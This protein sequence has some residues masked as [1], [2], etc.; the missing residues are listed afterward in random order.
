MKIYLKIFKDNNFGNCKT[1]L[2]LLTTNKIKVS[3]LKQ[4]IF[5]KYGIEKSIQRL[6]IKLFNK[7]FITMSEEFPLLFFKIKE[8]SIIFVEILEKVKIKED[9]LKKIKQREGKSKYLRRLNIFKKRPNMDIIQESEIED[10]DDMG[11]KSYSLIDK[12]KLNLDDT[13]NNNINNKNNIN[14]YSDFNKNIEKRFVNAVIN[15]KLNEFREIITHYNEFID[16]N[17]PIRNNKKYSVIHYASKNEY[18]EMMEDL[19]N[20]YNANVNLISLDGWS[21]LHIS[22]Y[23]GNLKII[24]ILINFKKT[25]FDLV[26]PK[27][28]T[29]LHCACK[30]NN[31]KTVALL[32]YKC[33]PNIK[34]ENGLL[35]IDL[36]IDINIKKLISKNLNIFSDF[37]ENINDISINR[38]IKSEKG[39]GERLTK[40]QLIEF[41]FL[42]NLSFIPPNPPRFIGYIYKKGKILSHYNLR[43]I[44]INAVKN[45]FIRFLSK[46]DYP[47]KPKEVLSLKNIISCKKK[48]TSEEGKFY[49]EIMFNDV[50]HL[51]R[52]DSLK[53]CNTWVDEINKCIIYSKF[54]TNLEKKYPDVQAFLCTLKQDVYE[55][56]YLT[57]EVR[58][59][60]LNQIKKESKKNLDFLNQNIEK[61]K[62]NNVL[63]NSLLNN[64]NLGID[65]F[66][67]IDTMGVGN[68]GK[69]YKVKFR[70]NGEILSMRVL[71]KKYL[72]K[73]NLLKDVI[74]KCN[75]LLKI[76]SPFI[77]TLHFSFHT[78]ENLYLAFDFFPGGD[79]NFHRMHTLFDEN[80]AKFYIAEIILAI[81]YLHKLDLVYKNFNFDNILITE[82]NHIKLNEYELIKEENFE[83]QNSTI[84]GIGK[85]SDIYGIGAI[86]YE[87]I[88]G[89]PPYYST[90]F[91][92]N[93][94]NKENELI[95]H[96]YFSDDL[97]DLLSKLLCKNT[98]KRLGVFNKEE[99]KNHQWFND[100]DWDKLSRKAIDP[101]LNLVLMKKEI[102]ENINNNNTNEVENKINL[103]N[104]NLNENKE[105][106]KTLYSQNKISEFT[107]IRPN[108]KNII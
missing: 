91:K 60:E 12:N 24:N 89:S 11:I 102:E 8:K 93:I 88:S 48:K 17:K 32:L 22:A 57:G 81:E 55:I 101:P 106:N 87:M 90:N 13:F 65:S 10:I 62:K 73:N 34:N 14:D 100:I 74:D 35:P 47:V 75:I 44:E 77:I 25:N 97:K 26:L 54:W 56:D 84:R 39:I 78:S 99:I 3:D 28:G 31:F 80:E 96:D 5:Q 71:D 21:P 70:L 103:E 18:C 83:R 61:K 58:K 1:E 40:A 16:I 72:V 45:I 36:T 67:I 107:F 79:L 27:I 19:I 38:K 92:S 85:F 41:K 63:G 46:D 50:I 105:L 69:V 64:T 37:E 52:F 68:F 98:H 7:Q 2:I 29:A 33:N 51:Y 86:L 108:D 49:I 4:I 9:M 94:K 15:N 23:K 104:N 82:D 20:K 30:N 43:Y 95:F 53:A 76:T 66:D 59:Y 6:T 42:R